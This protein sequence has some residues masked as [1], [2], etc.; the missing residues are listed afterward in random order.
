MLGSR[1]N[2]AGGLTALLCVRVR[3]SASSFMLFVK[4][5]VFSFKYNLDKSRLLL[6]LSTMS[7]P[8][9]LPPD[10]SM[11]VLIVVGTSKPKE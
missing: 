7:R 3:L 5:R 9:L 1:R 4:F 6:Y 11:D 10:K 8:V 2:D